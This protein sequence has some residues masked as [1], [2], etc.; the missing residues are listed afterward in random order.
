[1]KALIPLFLLIV[2]TKSYALQL[3]TQYDFNSKE[4]QSITI[5]H[6][7]CETETTDLSYCKLINS[8]T[9]KVVEMIYG[10]HCDL[11][12]EILHKSKRIDKDKLELEKVINY[13]AKH[14]KQMNLRVLNVDGS[15]TSIPLLSNQDSVRLTSNSCDFPLSD[16]DHELVNKRAQEVMEKFNKTQVVYKNQFDQCYKENVL[17][18][19]STTKEYM[20]ASLGKFIDYTFVHCEEV[21]VTEYK[22]IPDDKCM[23][24]QDKVNISIRA[25]CLHDDNI[26]KSYVDCNDDI[27]CIDELKQS[28]IQILLNK[29]YAQIMERVYKRAA[30]PLEN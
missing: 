28:V 8:K 3:E 21:D 14:S 25:S 18:K 4:I 1:M 2:T 29:G 20:A 9:Q 19:I 15:S 6:G 24:L 16:L 7:S 5:E 23:V 17:L 12:K 27:E 26:E 11:N 13:R 10:D 30:S 22:F